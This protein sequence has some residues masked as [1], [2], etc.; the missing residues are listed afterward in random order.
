MHNRVRD[1]IIAIVLVGWMIAASR[2]PVMSAPTPDEMK[3]LAAELH[4]VSNQ[5]AQMMLQL[6]AIT[7]HLLDIDK[8][9]DVHRTQLD[10]LDPSKDAARLARLEDIERHHEN[11]TAKEEA[12][13]MESRKEVMSWLRIVFGGVLTLG[14]GALAR[15]RTDKKRHERVAGQMDRMEQATNGVTQRLVKTTGEAE[16]AKGVIEGRE[17]K[18]G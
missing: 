10:A 9:L 15:W 13:T 16:H 11:E 3:A 5:H 14:I 4:V 2:I 1:K 17:D 8:R 12:A 18:Q 7:Q 6:A